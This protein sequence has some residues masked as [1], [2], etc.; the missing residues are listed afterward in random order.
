MGAGWNNDSIVVPEVGKRL[1]EIGVQAITL[2]PRTTK[3]R[4]T[5]KAEWKYMKFKRK[6]FNPNNS[7]G[8]VC[9][10]N[11]CFKCLRILGVIQ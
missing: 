11:I 5:G 8:D 2:H 7:N 10:T 3:Q 9:T 1:E 4:Y 6:L